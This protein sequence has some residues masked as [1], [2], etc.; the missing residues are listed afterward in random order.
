MARFNTYRELGL[1]IQRRTG[2]YSDRDP[3]DI[4]KRYSEKYNVPVGDDRSFGDRAI[5]DL[6]RTVGE[7][8]GG[9]IDAVSSPIQTAKG[10]GMLAGG[11]ADIALGTDFVDDEVEQAARGAG[12]QFIDEIRDFENRPVRAASNIALG[13]GLLGAIGKVGRAGK[14]ARAGRMIENLD[15]LTAA[16]RTTGAVA[17]G[18]GRAVSAPVRK[19]AKTITREGDTLTNQVARNTLGL[20]SSAGEEAINQLSRRSQKPESRA[21]IEDQLLQGDEAVA[22]AEDRYLRAYV[23]NIRLADEEYGAAKSQLIQNEVWDAPLQGNPQGYIA[24]LFNDAFE[25]SNVPMQAVPIKERVGRT[26]LN[27]R[28]LEVEDGF[29]EVITGYRVEPTNSLRLSPQARREFSE[30]F[31]GL[32]S[33]VGN[34]LT[35]GGLDDIKR[36]VSSQL[37]DLNTQQAG[38]Q[39][40]RR[41]LEALRKN[42]SGLL[43]GNK[44]YRELMR[45]YSE[46]MNLKE[47]LDEQFGKISVDELSTLKRKVRNGERLTKPDVGGRLMRAFDSDDKTSKRQAALETLEGAVGDQ[48][49]GDLALGAKLQPFSGKGLVGRAE[50][51]QAI[52]G[53]LGAVGGL[54][55]FGLGTAATGSIALGAAAGALTAIPAWIMLSPRASSR[56]ISHMASKGYNIS[57]QDVERLKKVAPLIEQEGQKWRNATR[58]SGI[59]PQQAIEE[60]KRSGITI[61]ELARIAAPTTRRAAS[62]TQRIDEEQERQGQPNILRTLGR[63]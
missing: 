20:Y 50:Q 21:I 29:D 8:I 43:E 3:E 33:D 52:R 39:D 15:P 12:R 42:I 22:R 34:R 14:L 63:R 16:A 57:R 26:R 28:G 46:R 49:L 10:I 36:R 32:Q 18:T 56:L 60:L 4:G 31:N 37:S 23:E 59:A 19:A 27:E 44:D 11:A 62:Q 40:T 17:R 35:F 41:L 13:G 5:D 47:A 54:G 61:G 48:D 45:G 25:A 53:I 30:L 2:A 7:D 51:S 1:E 24:E 38:T 9:I 55:A 6:G 58:S